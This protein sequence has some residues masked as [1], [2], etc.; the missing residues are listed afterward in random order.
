MRVDLAAQVM[1]ESVSKALLMQ[2]EDK[3]A[4]SA[5]FVLMMDR[6]FDCLNVKG[7]N[8]GLKKRKPFQDPYRSASDFRLK[9]NLIKGIVVIY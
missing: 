7:F 1:S 2:D 6:F 3:Y 5:E 8:S 9:V 4:G